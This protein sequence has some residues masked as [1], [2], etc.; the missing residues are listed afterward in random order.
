MTKDRDDIVAIA[1]DKFGTHVLC[2]AIIHRELEV[3]VTRSV[4]VLGADP[5]RIL[6]LEL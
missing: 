6:S 5:V 2:K 1:S 4:I 3:S